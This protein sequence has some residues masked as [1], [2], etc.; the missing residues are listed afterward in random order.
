MVMCCI[1]VSEP[2]YVRDLLV[3]KKTITPSLQFLMAAPGVLDGPS[4][5]LTV[6]A[7]YD[8]FEVE[9]CVRLAASVI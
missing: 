1:A 2:Y 4:D 6:L 3:R 7:H 9:L 8:V 5:Q